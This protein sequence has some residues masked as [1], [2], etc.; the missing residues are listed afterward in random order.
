MRKPERNL[1]LFVSSHV[2]G[3]KL[4]NACA[5]VSQR[6]Y[7][8]AHILRINAEKAILV[9]SKLQVKIV[10]VCSDLQDFGIDNAYLNLIIF[11]Q[12]FFKMS[13]STDEF[14]IS[15]HAILFRLII[16]LIIFIKCYGINT[17]IYFLF[18][19]WNKLIFFDCR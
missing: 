12:N 14:Q 17:T 1:R 11:Y 6:P 15:P 8:T 9:C 19:S 4:R 18:S 3:Y 7:Y 10:T 5:F 2:V 16:N 13:L